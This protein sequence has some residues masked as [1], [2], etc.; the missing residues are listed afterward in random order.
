MKSRL[1]RRTQHILAVFLFSLT[2][3]VTSSAQELLSRDAYRLIKENASGELPFADFRR[4]RI[5][6]PNIW[7]AGRMQ[8]G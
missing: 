3:V 6:L 1:F 7:R 8:C 2:A 5:K 4:D